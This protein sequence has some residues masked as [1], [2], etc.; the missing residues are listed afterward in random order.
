MDETE[1]L[2]LTQKE[3]SEF[4]NAL[5]DTLVSSIKESNQ[6]SMVELLQNVFPPLLERIEMIASAQITL[7]RALQTNRRDKNATAFAELFIE[8]ALRTEQGIDPVAIHVIPAEAYALAAEM[9][10]HGLVAEKQ[11]ASKQ[12]ITE[13]ALEKVDKNTDARAFVDEFFG[14]LS[15]AKA[16]PKA[17]SDKKKH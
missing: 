4:I 8:R 7:A 6:E 10:L 5:R 2:T 15:R 1:Q 16:K 3:L 12:V 9:D 13:G 17:A 14:R 11:A